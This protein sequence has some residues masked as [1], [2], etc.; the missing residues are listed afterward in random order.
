MFQLFSG[1]C[2][3]ACSLADAARRAVRKHSK[4]LF[5]IV[6]AV[7]ALFGSGAAHAT[8]SALGRPVSGTSVASGAGEVPPPG[9]TIINLQQVYMDGSIGGSRPVPIGGQLSLGADAKVAMTVATVMRTWGSAGGWNFGSGITLPYIWESVHATLSGQRASGTVG[10]RVSN[11]Y[12][13]YFTPIVAGYSLTPNDHIALSFNFYAPT[14]NYD[15]KALANA[16]QN[17][18]TFIPQVAYTKTLPKYGLEFD[19]VMGFQFYT[20]NNA[21]QYQNAPLFTLDVMGLKTFANGVGVGLVMGTTQQ[22]GKDSGPLATRLD[23]FV[24]SDFALGPIVTYKTRIA[25]KMP[26]SASLRWVPVISSSNRL[27]STNTFLGSATVA[28]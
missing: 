20:R 16:G 9:I 18:W 23:G 8:E 25:A 4:P 15:P 6:L 27:K 17:T 10:D 19:A 11:L 14:G 26:L 21:T 22:L 12:D 13:L 7:P 28:F 5:P 2:R 24:G 3:F 1:S